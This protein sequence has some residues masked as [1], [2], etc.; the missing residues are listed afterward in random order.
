MAEG[1]TSEIAKGL[2]VY[3][4]TFTGVCED[5]IPMKPRVD[6]LPPVATDQSLEIGGQ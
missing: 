3:V 2:Q 6:E 5:Y 1:F 4:R